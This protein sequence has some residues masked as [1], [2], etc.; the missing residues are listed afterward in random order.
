MNKKFEL[1]LTLLCT[2]WT[3]MSA[4]LSDNR[5]STPMYLLYIPLLTVLNPFLIFYKHIKGLIMP[6]YFQK[7]LLQLIHI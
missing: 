1:Y 7:T 5:R 3:K 4:V 2:M 6:N